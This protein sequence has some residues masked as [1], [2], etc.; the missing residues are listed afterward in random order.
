MSNI[1]QKLKVNKDKIKR[2]KFLTLLNQKFSEFLA[3][4]EYSSE[5]SCIKYAAFPKWDN[6]G[7]VQTTT[8]GS[9]KNWNNFSF[10][11]WHELITALQKFQK[12][13]NYIGW[14]FVDADGPYYKIS[15]NAFLSYIENLSDFCTTYERYD[16]GWIG[17]V[18]DIGII[19]GRN[20]ASS[21]KKFN[22]SIW[23]I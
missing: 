11:T 8:R 20:P 21:N 10:K 16:F 7:N 23:G 6:T 14:F 5:A 2:E 17:E 22:I 3:L 12:V 4:S 1:Q 9:V 19:I 15:I 18:D 13:K